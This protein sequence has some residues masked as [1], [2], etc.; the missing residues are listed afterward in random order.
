VISH[1]VEAYIDGAETLRGFYGGVWPNFHDAEVVELHLWRGHL[2]P[3]EWDDRNIFPILTVKLLLLEATQSN[4]TGRGN[5]VLATVRFHDVD[6]L[7]LQDFNHNNSIVALTLNL[8]NR[9]FYTNGEPLPPKLLVNVEQG[10]GLAATFSCTRMEIVAAE[11]AVP[12]PLG[13]AQS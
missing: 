6:A 4:A 5:D 3:G 8:Q 1:D 10:F 2:Y 7:R 13:R 11:R 12:G 9:G